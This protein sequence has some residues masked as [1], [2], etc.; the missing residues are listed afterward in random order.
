MSAVAKKEQAMRTL[1]YQKA[2]RTLHKN[3]II[4]K[5]Q[6]IAQGKDLYCSLV[7]VR[8]F[9]AQEDTLLYRVLFFFS[10]FNANRVPFD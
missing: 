4:V 2:I 6:T 3:K 7:C 1:V 9:C 8:Y 5:V 10:F